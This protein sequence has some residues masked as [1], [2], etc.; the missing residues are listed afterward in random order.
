L[1]CSFN[2]AAILL[3]FQTASALRD[4]RNMEYVKILGI[5]YNKKYAQYT[6]ITKKF[7]DFMGKVK[8]NNIK[9]CMPMF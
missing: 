7:I 6:K 4:D 8:Y 9:G 3:S 5:D 1:G 2:R